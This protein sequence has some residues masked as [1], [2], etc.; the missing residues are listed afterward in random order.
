MKR[1]KYFKIHYR[2]LKALN[3]KCKNQIRFHVDAA[4]AIGKILVDVRE[5]EVDFLTIVGHK[6]RVL[7]VHDCTNIQCKKQIAQ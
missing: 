4:Q 5:L 7:F 3:Q 2:E 1:F 6:V